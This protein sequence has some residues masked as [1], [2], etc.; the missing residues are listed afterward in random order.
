M[1]SHLKIISFNVGGFTTNKHTEI[2][3]FIDNNPSTHILCIQETKFS[4]KNIKLIPG[5]NC[6]FK[7]H[8]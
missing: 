3:H 1:D 4:N 2:K 8:I 5:Y 7:N 6:E